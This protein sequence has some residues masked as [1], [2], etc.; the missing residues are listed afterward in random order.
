MMSNAKNRAI[1]LE[2][3]LLREA[4]VEGNPSSHSD[5]KMTSREP[6]ARET[7][8]WDDNGSEHWVPWTGYL[9]PMRTNCFKKKAP[10]D[11]KSLSMTELR[12]PSQSIPA[13]TPNQAA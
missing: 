6:G 8:Y 10:H 1:H 13:W 9:V 2:K 11:A 12:P 4:L 3:R 5:L 7:T